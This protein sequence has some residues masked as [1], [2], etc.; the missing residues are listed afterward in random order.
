MILRDLESANQP[1]EIYQ[2]RAEQ[3]ARK[4]KEL[5]AH[6]ERFVIVGI[7]NDFQAARA[8]QLY[9]KSLGVAALLEDEVADRIKLSRDQR[10]EV[11]TRY[12]TMRLYEQSPPSGDLAELTDQLRNPDPT[13]AAAAQAAIQNAHDDVESQV[14]DVLDP[15]QVGRFEELLEEKIRRRRK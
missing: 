11:A 5:I 10:K 14:W 9:W 1:R 3:T 15:E 7:L 12:K 2:R 8:K 6:A 4:T 13:V